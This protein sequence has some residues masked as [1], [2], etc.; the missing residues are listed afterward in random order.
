MRQCGLH[1]ERANEVIASVA[2]NYR[3]CRWM[4]LENSSMKLS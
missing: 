2:I 3:I 1:G 4:M